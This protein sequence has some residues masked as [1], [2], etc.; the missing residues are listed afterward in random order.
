MVEAF[1]FL[2]AYTKGKRE[3]SSIITSIYLFPDVVGSDPLK[4]KLI[5]LNGLVALIKLKLSIGFKNLTLTSLQSVHAFSTF[6][7][8]PKEKGKFLF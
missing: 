6:F 4:S 8:S 7:T 5:L 2:H 3:Y 1:K